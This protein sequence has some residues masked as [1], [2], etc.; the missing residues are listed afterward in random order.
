M[1]NL[2]CIRVSGS[3]WQML[4]EYLVLNKTLVLLLFCHIFLVSPFC[5]LFNTGQHCSSRNIR[6]C[7]PER[8]H[9]Q[10]ARRMKGKTSSPASDASSDIFHKETVRRRLCDNVRVFSSFFT[11]ADIGSISNFT[12]KCAFREENKHSA[13]EGRR[14]VAT[15]QHVWSASDD[16]NSSTSV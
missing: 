12:C 11:S 13:D 10:G 14:A 16:A 9:L 6:S 15:L 1:E 8:R 2:S 4:R 5:F 7:S 3:H